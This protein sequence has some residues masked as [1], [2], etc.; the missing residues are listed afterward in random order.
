MKTNKANAK[1][2][3][4]YQQFITAVVLNGSIPSTIPDAGAL[5][6]TAS[7]RDDYKETGGS[8]REF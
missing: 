1:E 4:G 6:S 7:N 3:D 2:N 8:D 5:S